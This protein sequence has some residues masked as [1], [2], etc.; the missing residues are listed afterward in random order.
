MLGLG[1]GPE[2]RKCA[3]A[4]RETCGQHS[5][6]GSVMAKSSTLHNSFVL[7]LS[8]RLVLRPSMM[9]ILQGRWTLG[10]ILF[11]TKEKV[12]GRAQL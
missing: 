7:V 11:T 1:H 8:G 4:C 10:S 5:Q 2:P 9:K 6:P 3:D 12:E